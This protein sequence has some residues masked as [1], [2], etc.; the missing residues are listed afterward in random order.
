M[1]D[2]SVLLTC[3]GM[4][5]SERIHDLKNNED[6]VCV[7][8]FA[9]NSNIDNL[10]HGCDVEG[11]FV[12]PP[13]TAP[14]YIST[15]IEICL[16]NKIDIII[17]T[18]T[19]ELQFMAEHRHEFEKHG[20]KVN[21]SSPPSIRI[22][23]NKTFLYNFYRDLMPP[24]VVTNKFSELLNFSTLLEGSPICI[25]FPD[26]CGGN[27]FAVIDDDKAYD[28]SYYNK[29]GDHHYIGWDS[30]KR[31]FEKLDSPIIAQKKID[32]IDYSVSALTVKGDVTHI[33][34]YY[35]F[36]MEH[37][38]I[39]HGKIAVNE[40]AYEIVKRLCLELCLDGNVCFDFIVDKQG[41]VYLLEINPRV[42]ASLP[43][44]TKAGVN[45]LYLRCKN[46]LGDY[47]DIER[48]YAVKEGLQMKKYHESRYFI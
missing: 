14:D 22:S 30:V 19:L 23:N 46:L 33:C 21:I 34:G 4:H 42:N 16:D 31:I 43:F 47:T 7:R 27:G 48:N 8:V 12:V 3:C 29:R 1:K 17:P 38:A 32:G 2:F 45:M 20:I 9:C 6:N 39:C 28:M 13:I 15:L 25:K 36:S 40:T 41:R 18:V 24:S 26:H 11:L 44:V 35:G 10:P 5:V 37:G